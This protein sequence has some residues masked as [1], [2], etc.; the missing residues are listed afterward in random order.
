LINQN[1][2]DNNFNRINDNENM[3]LVLGYPLDSN[4]LKTSKGILSGFQDSFFQTDETLNP[5]NSGGPLIWNNKIIGI[6]VAKITSDKVKL[7]DKWNP[8]LEQFH[9]NNYLIV[10][11]N[12]L[13]NFKHDFYYLNKKNVL[14]V[15]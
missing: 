6:N 15:A 11:K 5:G 3:V 4:H 10:N 2:E 14:Q 8:E 9:E 13:K 7:I 12:Y 1:P